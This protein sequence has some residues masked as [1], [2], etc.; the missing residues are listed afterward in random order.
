MGGLKFGGTGLQTLP[1]T[2]HLTDCSNHADNLPTDASQ[3]RTKARLPSSPQTPDPQLV[4]GLQPT[5]KP[6]RREEPRSWSSDDPIIP[7]HVITSGQVLS[8]A[9]SGLATRGH[10]GKRIPSKPPCPP[11]GVEARL[12][13]FL[14]WAR[15][16]EQAEGRKP[17][18][19]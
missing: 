8:S 16:E 7:R 13:S 3:S 17:V 14:E 5:G 1:W 11:L 4:P 2:N 18:C 6:S 12:V 19:S 9:R 10:S 15:R